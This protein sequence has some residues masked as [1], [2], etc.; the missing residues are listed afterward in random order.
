MK[1]GDKE[2]KLLLDADGI[3]AVITDS[4]TSLP[5]LMDVIQSFSKLSG[6]TVNW[7]KSETTPLSKSCLPVMVEKFTFKWVPKGMKYLGGN[8]STKFTPTTT[9]V[10]N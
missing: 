3:F 9:D 6:Y 4:L 7:N 2:H 5:Q 10:Q 1:A 8:N